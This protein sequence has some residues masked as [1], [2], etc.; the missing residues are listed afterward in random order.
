MACNLASAQ[1]R[2]GHDVRIA[3]E[4]VPAAAPVP[5][6]QLPPHSAIDLFRPP[7]AEVRQ[8]VHDCDVLHL[9]GVWE[10]VLL[11]VGRAARRAGKPYLVAP[12]GML[13][14]WSLT[15]KRWKKR[16]ALTLGFAKLLNRA[17]TLHTLNAD[18][19]D[20][21]QPL[22]LAAPVEVIP[23]GIFIDEFTPIPSPTMFRSRRPGPGDRPYILFLSRLHYK[24]GLD[25]LAEA[26][27]AIAPRHPEVDLVV[28]GPDGGAEGEFRSRIQQ[29]GL[30]PR[31]WLT[32][33]LYGDEKRSV[34]AGARVFCLPS[35]QEGFS[36]AILEALA[37]RV[38]V[39]ITENCHFPEVAEVGAGRVVALQADA[40]AGALDGLLSDAGER[41]RAAR[42]G[43]SL[44]EERFTWPRIAQ[45]TIQIYDRL[46]KS[47]PGA[48][49]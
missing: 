4:I 30:T 1:A 9:H 48:V 12:H 14:P 27:A 37:C 25:L 42:A 22:K 39:V 46:A 7:R 17:A 19:R 36:M 44:V 6:M 34:I 40:V 33:P 26:M 8:L 20:L 11:G 41:S 47:R 32:G 21:I 2:L 38:P 23:N 28:V 16:I 29:L 43:R 10:P 13:D 31:V 18:E 24:K 45:R 5:T 3:A 49:N 15:Q 35:R